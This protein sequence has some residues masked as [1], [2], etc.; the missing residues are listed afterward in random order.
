LI[1]VDT[2]AWKAGSLEGPDRKD[3]AEMMEDKTSA[4]LIRPHVSRE[5][6]FQALVSTSINP[7]LRV[8]GARPSHSAWAI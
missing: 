2:K 5:P 3:F 8:S 7:G 6:A 1:E 4:R